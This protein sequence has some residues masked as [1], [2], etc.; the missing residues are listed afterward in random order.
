MNVIEKFFLCDIMMAK[1]SII[2][3]NWIFCH[4]QQLELLTGLPGPKK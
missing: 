1:E 3:I 4:S 2:P